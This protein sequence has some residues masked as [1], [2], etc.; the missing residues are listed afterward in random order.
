[1]F[2]FY[3]SVVI[4]IIIITTDVNVIIIYDSEVCGN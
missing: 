3:D 1:M 2:V 4:I